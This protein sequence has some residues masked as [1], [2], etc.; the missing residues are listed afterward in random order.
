MTRREPNLMRSDAARRQYLRVAARGVHAVANA[1]AYAQE[2]GLS[3]PPR[4][5]DYDRL[6]E[7]G[8][9]R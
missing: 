1:R 3:W 6:Y 9:R 8:E 2:N 5:G 7:R 4:T